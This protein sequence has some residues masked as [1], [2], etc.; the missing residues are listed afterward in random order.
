MALG[1]EARSILVTILNKGALLVLA[2]VIAGGLIAW[3]L[4]R[5]LRSMLFEVSALDPVTYVAVAVAMLGVGLLAGLIP[6][7]KAARINPVI[8]LQMTEAGT[9]S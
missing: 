2:G 6:A 4:S 1:A 9:V 5:W 7:M 8:A 3:F